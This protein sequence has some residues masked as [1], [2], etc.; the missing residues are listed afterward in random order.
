MK[1]P[2]RPELSFLIESLHLGP[3][4][5]FETFF[6]KSSYRPIGVL[7]NETVW[8]LTRQKVNMQDLREYNSEIVESWNNYIKDN[9]WRS[10]GEKR[11]SIFEFVRKVSTD[12]LVL[13]SKEPYFK[14]DKLDRWQNV[15]LKCG[16]DLFVAAMYADKRIMDGFAPKH[17][18]WNYILDSDY[19]VLNN[20]IHQKKLVENH[21]HLGGSSPNVDL[22]WIR[23]MNYPFGQARR[24]K[25]L[26]KDG[27]SY[28]VSSQSYLPYYQ[29]KLKVLVQIAACVRVWLFE[30]CVLGIVPKDT[31]KSL[32][33]QIKDVFDYN[34][35]LQQSEL[36]S[37]IDAYRYESYYSVFD[38]KVD[39]AIRGFLVDREGN[40]GYIAGERHLFY[41]CL[42]YIFSN[43]EDSFVQSLFYF[44][45]LIRNHFNH[46]FIQTNNKTGFQNFKEYSDRKSSFI[47]DTPYEKMAKNMAI[48]GSIRENHLDQLEVR[49]MPH[50]TFDKMRKLIKDT[51]S[52]AYLR[53][54]FVTL[55]DRVYPKGVHQDQSCKIE[56]VDEKFFYV[57]HFI[58]DKEMHWYVKEDNKYAPMCRE[59]YKRE[60]Y[61]Q[62]AQCFMDMRNR[63][64]KI[65]ERI[66]GIDAASNEVNFRPENFGTVFRYLS[67]SR[68][69]PELLDNKIPDLH[70][71][72]HVGEDFY[73][74][75]D[76]LRAIDEAILYLELSQGDRIGHGV[77]LGIDVGKWYERHPVVAMP[78]QNKV[79]NLGW[80]LSKIRDWNINIST[81][82][83]Y[84]LYTEFERGC[85]RLYKD[86]HPDL[87]TYI[88]AW[89]L[90]GDNPDCY[91][92][93]E[94]ER[95]WL[96][97]VTQWDRYS[98]R[99]RK[100]YESLESNTTVYNLYHRYHFDTDLKREAAKV[101][102]FRFKPYYIDL[103]KQLQIRMRSFML[104][105]GVAVESCPTS[106]FLISNVDEFKDIPT[107]QLFPIRESHSDFV[108]LNVS[109][110]T[111]DKGVFYTSLAKEYSLLAG[112]LRKEMENGLR[113]H[114]DDKILNWVEHLI[115]NSKQQCFKELKKTNKETLN[116][117]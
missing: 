113:V 51:D 3:N 57:L 63:K 70:K 81:A 77:A 54:P 95:K 109:I 100:L 32:I 40:N 65:C 68:I 72:Y 49:V 89:K 2:N 97:P 74:V 13:Q 114:S 99:D 61:R 36:M 47:S 21:Y 9:Q 23:L 17:F 103:V 59:H 16:E 11:Q 56:K 4:E 117:Y 27:A 82:N 86:V 85:Q 29:T 80:I 76:G 42:Y 88:Q 91:F 60:I 52:K 92:S 116:N 48:E 43:H 108:R 12:C 44:Y 10:I 112:T 20:L 55:Y 6:K 90:R 64:E 107:F 28:Y 39:Y 37:Q 67:S 8:E 94:F 110:N 41:S 79:D 69:Q 18:Q 25:E 22:S 7:L 102:P 30:K 1:T 31:T 115:N 96:H 19:F 35:F 24:Y 46:V 15:T 66:F 53:K 87:M 111:D 84:N 62:K 106:N 105:K 26:L 71:T 14:I 50:E 101:E 5:F 38:A 73:E 75:A 58:K 33:S 98:I 45:L 83:Y 34:L 78:L 104:E 93:P